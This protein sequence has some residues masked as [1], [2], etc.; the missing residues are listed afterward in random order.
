[1]N[2]GLLKDHEFV[3]LYINKMLQRIMDLEI[4]NLELEAKVERSGQL[5][6]EAR[7]VIN[8]YK[9]KE[10]SAKTPSPLDNYRVDNS[11]AG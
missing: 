3:K 5:L 1:M 4:K 6:T 10:E 8:E 9:K 2:E 11:D 7:D